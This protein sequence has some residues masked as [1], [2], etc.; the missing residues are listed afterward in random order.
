MILDCLEN[1]EKYYAV[2][3]HFKT[4]F[5]FLKTA[6]LGALEGTVPIDGKKVYALVIKA[7]GTGHA[8]AELENHKKYIDMQFGIGGINE[9][10]WKPLRDCSV[11]TKPFSDEDDYGFFGENPDVWVSVKPGQ[12]AIFFPEDAHTPKGGTGPLNKV[13]VKVAVD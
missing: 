9:F 3:P 1:A 2:N 12:Y 6:D 7:Q 13:L 11:V 10:G 8:G 4:A 5:E